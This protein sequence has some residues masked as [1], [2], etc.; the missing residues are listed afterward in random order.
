LIKKQ[1]KLSRVWLDNIEIIFLI[2][3]FSDLFSGRKKR[4]IGV[5][6]RRFYSF[7]LGSRRKQKTISPDDRSDFFILNTNSQRGLIFGFN[8][9]FLD[10]IRRTHCKSKLQRF[11]E[12]NEKRTLKY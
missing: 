8:N 1:H 3:I 2:I 12:K 9:Y 4:K 6:L 5:R 10:L 11:N 7:P